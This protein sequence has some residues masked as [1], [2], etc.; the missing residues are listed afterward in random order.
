MDDSKYSW[1]FEIWAQKEIGLFILW[2]ILKC[3]MNLNIFVSRKEREKR[4]NYFILTTFPL[5]MT[6]LGSSY[7]IYRKENSM[8]IKIVLRSSYTSFF[9]LL[10][11][12]LPFAVGQWNIFF[13]FC[14][15]TFCYKCLC[16][17]LLR[18]VFI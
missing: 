7:K 14:Y 18:S 10:T 8:T 2:N 13:L 11:H 1:I 3:D 9:S 5:F 15:G 12:L 17:W 16:V 6:F 4:Q